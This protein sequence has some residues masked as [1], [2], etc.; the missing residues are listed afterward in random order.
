LAS[1][2][3]PI[4]SSEFAEELAVVL[5]PVSEALTAAGL[6]ALNLQSTQ[7]ELSPAVIATQWLE[8]NG[9]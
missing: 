7:D 6:V 2:V 9:F 1:N 4:V 8:A 5:N 3:V